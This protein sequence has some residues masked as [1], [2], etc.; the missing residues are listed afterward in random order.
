MAT[1]WLK[2]RRYLQRICFGSSASNTFTSVY[3]SKL[4][5]FNSGARTFIYSL[6]QYP[7]I[8]VHL[9]SLV[10]ALSLLLSCSAVPLTLPI[11]ISGESLTLSD[12]GQTIS[13]GDKTV[14]LHQAMNGATS[15]QSG[16]GSK[17]STTT[18]LVTTAKTVYFISNEANNSIVALKVSANGTLSGGLI[19]ATGGSG[20]SGVN[21]TGSP[22]AP[23][24]LFSQ[25]AIKI[26]G[27]VHTP[28][29]VLTSED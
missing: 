16:K 24:S 11:G 2:G 4:V 25:G 5:F 6:A 8:M 20:M 10:A 7:T 23:D 26:S 22:A 15:C 1:I 27:N 18:N 17:N 21:S 19:T 28:S 29:F 12:D 3:H 14:N 13:I 9:H